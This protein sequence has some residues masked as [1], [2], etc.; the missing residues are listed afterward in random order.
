M[1]AD[2]NVKTKHYLCNMKPKIR[3]N[4]YQLLFYGIASVYKHNMIIES[5]RKIKNL[6][7]TK[8]TKKYIENAL[9][10]YMK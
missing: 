3:L 6:K 10:Y 4:N 5:K 1:N 9:N 8:N 7:I 2:I